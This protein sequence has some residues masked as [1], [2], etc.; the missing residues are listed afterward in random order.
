M[1]KIIPTYHL[2]QINDQNSSL[3]DVFYTDEKLFALK[4]ILNKPYRSNYYGLGLC[5]SGNANLVGN[6]DNYFVEPSALITMSPQVI[7]QW[8]NVSEDFNTLTIFFTKA[9]FTKIFAN[10]NYLE[11]FQYFDQNAQHVNLLSADET[12][13]I[14][15][16]FQKIKTYTTQ[17]HPYQ[18]EILASYI[19]IL[20]FE[21]R[22][23][24]EQSHLKNNYQ[25]TRNQQIV[26]AFK[27]LVN[28]HFQQERSVKFYA[29]KLFITAKY[30]TEVLKSETGKTASEWINELLILEA[31]V[32]LSNPN[33]QITH[34]TEVLHFPDA[35]TFGKFFKNL[36]GT[37]PLQY[38]KTL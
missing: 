30:L 31:K 35:S 15:A 32:L 7:K 29:D 2:E 22:A 12:S 20:L 21:F 17:T 9:F 13:I 34:I 38:R 11:Q 19:N 26:T 36:S 23:I 24:Y 10:Q 18:N 14:A 1:K 28:R 16:L 8:K 25:H 5:I 6:L 33:L 37:S 27:D 4:N 3:N